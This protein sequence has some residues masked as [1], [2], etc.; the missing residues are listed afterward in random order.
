M[1]RECW[2]LL[3]WFAHAHQQRRPCW[4][5][6]RRSYGW[7]YFTTIPHVLLTSHLQE[8]GSPVVYSNISAGQPTYDAIVNQTGCTDAPDTLECLRYVPY[9]KL[10]SVVNGMG[11]FESASSLSLGWQPLIDGEVIADYPLALLYEGKY[12]K[13]RIR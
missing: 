5:I 12:A 6:P 3:S 4:S 10:L 8:S 7:S 2:C 1:G 11:S 13:V 9:E